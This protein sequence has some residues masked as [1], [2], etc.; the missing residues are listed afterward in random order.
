MFGKSIIC[1]VA[2]FAMIA[3]SLAQEKKPAS[4]NKANSNSVLSA[5]SDK[6]L[7]THSVIKQKPINPDKPDFVGV[8]AV[9]VDP[10]PR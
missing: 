4:V 10:G 7:N 1:A 6:K 2:M 9:I 3:P 5:T 8:P